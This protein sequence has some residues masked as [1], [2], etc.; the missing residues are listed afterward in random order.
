[1]VS[2]KT[3]GT[4]AHI[5]LHAGDHPQQPRVRT[6]ASG[7]GDLKA[8]AVLGRITASGK[9]VLVDSGS[10]DGSQEPYGILG[11]DVNATA[12]DKQ[13]RVYLSGHFNEEALSFGG[14]DTVDTHRAALR[15][16]GI[17]LSN[18]VDA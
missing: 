9:L 15:D 12:A 6:I 4:R 11:E 18:N 2:F 16:L 3:E 14:A 17:Y 8:G 7:A 13:A 1:M 10:A 5:N